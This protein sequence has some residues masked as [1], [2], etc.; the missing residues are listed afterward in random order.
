L[1]ERQGLVEIVRRQPVSL[2]DQGP[3]REG[4]DTAEA[5]Q[6]NRQEDQEQGRWPRRGQF[7][8]DVQGR[9]RGDRKNAGT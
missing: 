2:L 9:S 6:G 8:G 7:I 3:T 5:L 1:A 4:Q